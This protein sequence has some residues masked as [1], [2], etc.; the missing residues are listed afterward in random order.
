MQSKLE[1]LEN[2]SKLRDYLQSKGINFTTLADKLGISRTELY[3][4]LNKNEMLEEIF[5]A[6]A[7]PLG[8]EL[9]EFTYKLI[10]KEFVPIPVYER[11]NAGPLSP[12]FVSE[13]IE[14]LYLPGN[15]KNRFAL[16][17]N[18][19]SMEPTIKEGE[20]IVVDPDIE[21]LS[22]DVCL[23]AIEGFEYTLKRVHFEMDEII[24]ISDNSSV[25]D[26]KTFPKSR[27]IQVFPVVMHIKKRD[28]IR[29]K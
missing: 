8:I 19:D 24:L 12:S 4:R 14:S 13:P 1:I 10:D 18:G 3:D 22:G 9:K 20:I 23:V 28:Q 21:A 17:V 11:V 27:V 5:N 7:N 26:R 15:G 16:K 29:R 25:Y 2:G 6:A